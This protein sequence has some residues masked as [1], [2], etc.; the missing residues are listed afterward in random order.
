MVWLQL[1]LAVLIRSAERALLLELAA[2]SLA[3]FQSILHFDPVAA[4]A[5][6]VVAVAD[7][8]EFVENSE[9]RALLHLLNHLR[10][11]S[12]IKLYYLLARDTILHCFGRA[13]LQ[14]G[15]L[16]SSTSHIHDTLD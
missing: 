3:L 1:V 7:W 9:S 6:D 15:N 2:A 16:H 14:M 12:Y 4:A 10:L 13:V 5:D 11:D 8:F